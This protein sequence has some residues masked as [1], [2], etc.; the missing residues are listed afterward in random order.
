MAGGLFQG[1]SKLLD[2]GASYLQHQQFVERLRGMQLEDAKTQLATYVSGMP[3][4]GYNGLRLALTLLAR[5]SNDPGTKKLLNGLLES[6]DAARE[7]AMPESTSETPPASRLVD[8]LP[9][10][11]FDDDLSLVAGW[12]DLDQDGRVAALSA[13]LAE[14]KPEAFDTFRSNV[15][16]MVNNVAAA[17]RE[18]EANEDNAMG[19]FVE[20]R[21][22]TMLARLK[23]GQRDPA[24][25]AR[26]G[27]LQGYGTFY[28]WVGTASDLAWGEREQQLRRQAAA[29][30]EPAPVSA[31]TDSDGSFLAAIAMLRKQL[32]DGLASGEIRPERR[33]SYERLLDKLESLMVPLSAA[34]TSVTEKSKLIERFRGL[35]A[36]FQ[37]AYVTPG[38]PDRL[39][40]LRERARARTL[41]TAIAEMKGFLYRELAQSPPQHTAG[42]AAELLGDL[43]RAHQEVAGLDEDEAAI[44]FEHEMLRITALGLH[45]Y[46]QREHLMLVRPLWECGEVMVSANGLFYSGRADLG[47]TVR[48][49]AARLRLDLPSERGQYYGQARW[50]ALRRCHVG[51]FDLRGYRP[52]LVQSDTAAGVA[53][54]AT[55]YELGLASALGKPVVIVTR[56]DDALPFDIDIVPCE[57]SGDAQ[58]DKQALTG[59][60][61]HAWYGRQR[62]LGSSSLAETLAFLD[63]ITQDHPRRRMLEATGLLDARQIDDQIGFI[64]SVKQILREQG[65]ADLQVIFPTWPGHYPEAE[66]PSV[67]HVMPFSEPW[68][69]EVRDIV[70]VTC[71]THGFAY[72]RGDEA[73]EGRIIQSIWQDTCAAHSVLV[74]LSGLNINVL[75]EL[76]M[77][78]ALGRIVLTVRQAGLKEPL[79]R[80]IEKLRVLDYDSPAGLSRLLESRLAARVPTS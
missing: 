56:P 11:S 4:V 68:S 67:F 9:S 16:Q 20:D 46:A 31:T 79:P 47:E 65:L 14:L 76:G 55:A 50:N 54:A 39:D 38:A 32:Q 22:N 53:L 2:A 69:N 17:I 6:L 23:T 71:K 27:E 19:G 3:D 34:G 77:A 52:G 10:R 1:L 43:T 66:I 51:V 35:M 21:M 61:D 25:L 48:D 44:A 7:G 37:Q 15:S 45:D 64:G 42:R 28:E 41:E 24:F 62:T 73:D 33:A 13:H 75:I 70:R 8:S 80:N 74:D 12:Y 57:I 26:L 18:F 40:R 36:E 78:H 5:N 29:T 60:L 72:R 58:T 63:Q 49:L 59:A 30:A